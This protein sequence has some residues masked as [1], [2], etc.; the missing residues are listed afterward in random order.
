[1]QRHLLAKLDLH[2]RNVIGGPRLASEQS[3]FHTFGAAPFDPLLDPALLPW[4]AISLAATLKE[5]AGERSPVRYLSRR[6]R[7]R[8]SE[9]WGDMAETIQ[10]GI[11]GLGIPC[12]AWPPAT[13]GEAAQDRQIEAEDYYQTV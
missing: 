9:R 10:I 5:K 13:T 12:F 4:L 2:R 3:H 11:G 1:M 8:F 6:R 7:V